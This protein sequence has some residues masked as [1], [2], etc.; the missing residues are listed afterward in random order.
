VY[1]GVGSDHGASLR[2]GIGTRIAIRLG[3]C[4][5]PCG[6]Q[7][8]SRVNRN[9]GVPVEDPHRYDE[10]TD[11]FEAEGETAE[12]PTDRE[13]TEAIAEHLL[14]IHRDSYGR[15]AERAVSNLIDDTLVVLLDGLEL[16]PNEEFLVQN[17]QGDAVTHLRSMYQKAIEPTFRAAVERATGRRV[18]GFASHVTL[19]EP[20]FALEIFRLERRS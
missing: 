19:Q 17:G 3:S 5:L 14:Q 12:R 6:D 11:P 13:V 15:S 8:F 1:H 18:I 9:W 4:P 16:L 2:D 10:P 7:V 20:R